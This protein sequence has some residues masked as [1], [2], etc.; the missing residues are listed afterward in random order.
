MLERTTPPPRP[1]LSRTWTAGQS[2]L[3]LPPCSSAWK[4]CLLAHMMPPVSNQ[5]LHPPPLPHPPKCRAFWTPPPN[6][7]TQTSIFERT[8]TDI[9]HSPASNANPKCPHFAGEIHVQVT[10]HTLTH[11]PLLFFVSQSQMKG[12]RETRCLFF[13]GIDCLVRTPLGH[14][15]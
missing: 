13:R 1:T 6:T 14:L 4:L 3:P 10:I 15:I 11:N 9:T 8:L 2:L 12:E 5:P 7:Q